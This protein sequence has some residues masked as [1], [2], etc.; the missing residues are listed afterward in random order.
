MIVRLKGVK[1]VRAKGKVY[2]YHRKT[3]TRLPGK[4]G[5]AEFIAKLQELERGKGAKAG[6]LGGL[7]SAYR[8]SPEYLGLAGKTKLT[9]QR[10]F[11]ILRP[12]D[13]MP[14]AVADEEWLYALR[15]KLAT[16]HGWASV[17]KLLETLQRV[18]SWGVERRRVKVNPVAGVKRLRRPRD[19]PRRN[20]PPTEAE[21]ETLLAEAKPP[22]RMAIMLAAYIG[23]RQGDVAKAAW[24]CYDGETFEM[25]TSKTGALVRVPVYSRLKAEL[26]ATPRRAMTIV[27]GAL[28]RPWASGGLRAEF[29]H[30]TRRLRA[31]G[32][33][34]EGLSFHGLRHLLATE[35]INAGGTSHAARSV[36]GHSQ[37]GMTE[38]YARQFDRQKLAADA[39]SLLEK[40][41][42]GRN[43]KRK[44]EWKTGA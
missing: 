16:D 30:L 29:F 32:R 12:A 7:I 26:D 10:N 8:A 19:A 22:L 27:V 35:I 40:R 17:N 20:R 39:I 36:L 11:E 5:S 21:F 4:P 31:E 23:L 1:R 38:R 14:L 43:V 34:G 41:E 24:S 6:T 13:A 28:G 37:P 15:D 42:Q 25:R 9:H 33:V 18:F 2:F 44:T 3:M